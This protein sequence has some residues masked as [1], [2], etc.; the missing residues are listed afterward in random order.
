MQVGRTA[1]GAF[2][3]ALGVIGLT[4]GAFAFA[5][6]PIP[7]DLPGYIVLAYVVGAFLLLAGAGVTMHRTR[8]VSAVVLLAVYGIF[9]LPWL[10]RVVRFPQLFGTWGGLAEQVSMMAAAVIIL[11]GMPAPT[12]GG[13]SRVETVC[14]RAF[15]V[16]AVVF[17]FNH[18]LSLAQ[19]AD[20]VPGWLPP[21]RMFWAITTGVF[22]C[23]AG[24]AILTDYRALLAARLLACMMLVFEALVWLPSLLEDPGSH[25]VWA[26]NA[27]DLALAAAAL[28]M[29]DALAARRRPGTAPSRD[30]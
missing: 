3:A 21:T 6:Q 7:P 26:G 5:W 28:V 16:C 29:A 11:S 22:H 27:T 23:A 10:I 8:R 30:R 19:T 20:M 18:F 12:P 15:G 17:G 13:A 4:W 9:A 24:I 25:M 14:I 2:S 1:F